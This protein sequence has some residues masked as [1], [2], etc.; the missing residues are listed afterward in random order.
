M[1]IRAEVLQ[2]IFHKYIPKSILFRHTHMKSI[3]LNKNNL[4]TSINIILFYSL[5]ILLI[6]SMCAQIILI[7]M[8]Q[9]FLEVLMA[10]F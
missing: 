3:K 4:V 8:W 2:R 10:Q 7:G 9:D 1:E 6:L 5:L